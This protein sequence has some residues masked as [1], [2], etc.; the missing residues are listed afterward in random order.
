MISTILD[1]LLATIL[2]SSTADTG[3]LPPPTQT[4]GS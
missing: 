2:A 3:S 1:I 4:P